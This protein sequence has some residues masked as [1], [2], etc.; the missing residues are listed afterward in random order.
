VTRSARVWN[1]D[2]VCADHRLRLRQRGL[3]PAA[4]WRPS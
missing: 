3:F 2:S 4:G 1:D